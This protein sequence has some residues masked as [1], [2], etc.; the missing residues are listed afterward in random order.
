MPYY[1]YECE[2]CKRVETVHKPVDHREAA[3]IVNCYKYKRNIRMCILTY[4]PS[5]ANFNFK[6]G[7]PT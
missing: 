3:E 6:G 4:K 1:E 2:Q 7:N 5:V